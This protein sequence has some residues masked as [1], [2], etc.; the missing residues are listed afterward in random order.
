MCTLNVGHYAPH[1]LNDMHLRFQRGTVNVHAHALNFNSEYL[2][3]LQVYKVA[4]STGTLRTVF[5]ISTT[6]FRVV[7]LLYKPLR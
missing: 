6:T 3:V 5:A 2:T 1:D 4:A 7:Q